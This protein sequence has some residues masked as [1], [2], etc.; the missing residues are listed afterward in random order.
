MDHEQLKQKILKGMGGKV[1]ISARDSWAQ[2][3]REKATEFRIRYEWISVIGFFKWIYESP[4]VDFGDGTET[5]TVW[6]VQFGRK[7]HDRPAPV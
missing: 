7:G 6:I 1:P 5:V 3:I 2:F 4:E